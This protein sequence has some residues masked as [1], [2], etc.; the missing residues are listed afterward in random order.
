M[1]LS[2]TLSQQLDFVPEKDTDN[3]DIALLLD[4]LFINLIDI[5]LQREIANT[6][7]L[8]IDTTAAIMLLLRKGPIDLNRISVIRQLKTSK[9]NSSS[10]TKERIIFQRTM[11]SE[12]RLSLN[13]MTFCLENLRPLILSRSIIGGLECRHSSKT[14]LKGVAYANNS[15]STKTHLHPHIT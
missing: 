13:T 8:D 7:N 15:R 12:R 14:P 5:K 2:D 3:K 6:D 1:I 11:I 4:Q 10:F 9:E